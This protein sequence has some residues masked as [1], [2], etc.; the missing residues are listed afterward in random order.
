MQCFIVKDGVERRADLEDL[1]PLFENSTRLLQDI[2]R[3]TG[4]SD[5]YSLAAALAGLPDEIMEKIYPN[6]SSRAG[7]I[8]RKLHEE[9]KFNENYIQGEKAKLIDLIGKSTDHRKYP[10]QFIWKE[11]NT[12]LDNLIKLIE[13]A[14]VSGEL[15]IPHE[16]CKIPMEDIQTAF[17]KCLNGLSKIKHLNIYGKNLPAAAL[18]FETEKIEKLKF[19]FGTEDEWPQFLEKCQNLLELDFFMTAG[20]NEFPSWIHSASSLRSLQ[21]WNCD[22]ESL[23]DWIGDL[24]SLTNLSLLSNGNL[25]ILPDSIGNLKNLAS[26]SLSYSPLKKLPESICNLKNLQ[27]LNLSNLAIEK[28]PDR[29]GNL[30]S[31]TSL[32]LTENENME[33]LPGIIGSLTNLDSLNLDKMPVKNLPDGLVNLKNLKN[34]NLDNS[35]MEKLPD[36][37]GGLQS[38]TKL[39]LK[40]CRNLKTLPDSIGN[41]KNLAELDLSNS[42]IEKLPDT[43][44]NC[45]A[46][47]SVNIVGTKI[48]SVPD[49]VSSLSK[50]TSELIEL[51]P[52]DGSISYNCFCNSYYKIVETILYYNDKARHKGL[53]ALEDDIEPLAESFFRIGIQAICDGTLAH[54][55]RLIL[56]TR[57]EREH[58][59]Y[60]KKLME[61]AMEGILHIQAG[62]TI[63]D[64]AFVMASIVDIKNNLLEAACEKY[65][66][67]DVKAFDNIDFE[68]AML[69][70]EEREEISLIKRALKLIEI[71]RKEGFFALEK[72]LDQEAVAARDILDYGLSLAIDGWDDDVIK[73]ILDNL[74]ERE[75]DPVRKKIAKAKNTA[76]TAI[77]NGIHPRNLFEYFCSHFD[78][79]ITQDI[80]RP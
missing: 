2:L 65:L 51:I 69:P 3:K 6:V 61:T 34:L 47:E 62:G 10:K 30:Q 71:S 13:E 15:D 24:Q 28:L 39:S 19:W 22:I 33:T 66:S 4:S 35:I 27:K 5:Y 45:T 44:V 41:L 70:E 43:I 67:G 20:L 14:C 38:L 57:I 49:S 75:T 63:V 9:Y 46:L 8:L 54:I 18:L 58:D 72:H 32:S 60:R 17:Q 40:N 42:H 37:I 36:W 79:S 25:K 16:T 76:A 23:P 59:F 21:F 77:C 12:L 29:L 64:I 73:K 31:L 55:V 80:E 1:L 11:P 26:L 50:F 53:L 74:V 48:S 52:Q 78:K 68:A 56:S 7:V